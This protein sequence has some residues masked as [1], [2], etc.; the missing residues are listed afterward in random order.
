MA[1]SRQFSIFLLK[2]EFT[3]GNALK[4]KHKLGMPVDAEDLPEG[5]TL[6]LSDDSPKPPWWKE[7]WG[8]KK[9]LKQSL[10]GAVVFL[11]V[12]NRTFAITF[13]HAYHNLKEASYEYDFGLRTTLNAI[14]PNKIKA[15]DSFKL[16]NAKRERIQSPVDADLTFF[17]FDRNDSIVKKL[18][19]AVNEEYSDIFKHVT[20]AHSLKVNSKI[21]ADGILELCKTLLAIY[22]K[23]DFKKNFPDIRYIVPIKDPDLLQRL[24]EELVKAF[25]KIPVP[26]ELV[27]AIPEIIDYS[28]AHHVKYSGAGRTQALHDDVYLYNYKEY[29]D[30]KRVDDISIEVFKKHH[31]EIQDDNGNVKK[32]YQI[33]RCFLFDCPLNSEHYHLCDGQWYRIE[34][35][36][37]KKLKTELDPVFIDYELLE[38]CSERH[39]SAYN[40]SVSRKNSDTVC[41]DCKNIAPKGQKA[42][43]PCDILAISGDT[44]HFI[45]NKIST[46]SFALSH[47]F[48]Q[49]LNSMILLRSEPDSL[50]KLK[51]LVQDSKFHKPIDNGNYA[52][53][54]GI[55]TKKDKSKKSNN[56]PIFS[57]ISLFRTMRDLKRM[58]IKGH[59]VL[60]N[61]NVDRKGLPTES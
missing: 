43:E 3:V 29:L 1:H 59:V 23:D 16:E 18:T 51:E 60:I 13:G 9:E 50:G 8:I 21:K 58:G 55:I 41:L 26:M 38:E 28:Q 2:N 53:I 22:N 24:N 27:L 48:N 6:Y 56:L 47:L 7:Y 61:D 33:F 39:E 42:V 5:A 11:P 10:K 12:D 14:D 19:G 46:R 36:Y 44:A 25:H 15:T 31:L 54:Y 52:V 32:S 34:K 17:D 35:E 20:G 37:L 49:G 40:Q 57:R 45:H 4:D 30:E